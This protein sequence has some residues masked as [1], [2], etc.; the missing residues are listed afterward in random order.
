MSVGLVVKITYLCSV[1]DPYPDL[2]KFLEDKYLGYN[3]VLQNLF[4]KREFN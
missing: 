3:Y 2:N 1:P 4:M